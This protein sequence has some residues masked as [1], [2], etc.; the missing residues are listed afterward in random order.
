MVKFKIDISKQEK[1]VQSLEQMPTKSEKIINETLESY[2]KNKLID[3]IK[4]LIPI[5]KRDKKHARESNPFKTEMIN[6]GIDIKFKKDFRYLIFP[7]LGI[8]KHNLVSQNFTSKGMDNAH[9][10]ILNKLLEKL[11]ELGELN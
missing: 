11:I 8:G 1:L 5:S 10:D 7:D 4:E 9:D 6:L 3:S 2:G